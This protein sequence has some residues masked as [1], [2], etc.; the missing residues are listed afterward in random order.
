MQIYDFVMAGF[1]YLVSAVMFW[2]MKEID[3][4]DSRVLPTAIAVILIVL[5]T[6][7]IITRLVKKDTKDTYDF[8]NSSRGVIMLGI[9]LVFALCSQWFGF[10][11]CTPFFLLGAMLFLGQRNK[12]I[13]ILVPICTTALVVILFRFIFQVS[14]PEGTIFNIFNLL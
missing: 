4:P 5:A 14:L 9:L 6:A 3:A 10:Y 8:K 13:L 7:L 1:M 2:Q 12:K 11:V